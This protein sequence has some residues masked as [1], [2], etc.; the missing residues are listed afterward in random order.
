MQLIIII[1]ITRHHQHCVFY[2]DAMLL[3]FFKKEIDLIPDHMG[4]ALASALHHFC[5]TQGRLQLISPSNICLNFL[6]IKD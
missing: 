1:I 5:V 3:K 6:S 2:D 4:L